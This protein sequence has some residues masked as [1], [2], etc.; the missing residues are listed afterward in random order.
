MLTDP[1]SHSCVSHLSL[2]VSY[3]FAKA[4][5]LSAILLLTFI[6]F[7]FPN[8]C[9]YLLFSIRHAVFEFSKLLYCVPH[10]AFY[11]RTKQPLVPF[12][13]IKLIF[14]YFLVNYRLS[15]VYNCFLPSSKQNAVGRCY[16]LYVLENTNTTSVLNRD[17]V[18]E[19]VLGLENV[20]EDAF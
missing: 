4:F 20:L 9:R 19:D 5:V 7:W 12:K 8:L 18:L 14:Y 13:K 16:L 10:F 11:F 15:T 3:L 2:F 17:G 1:P 6:S